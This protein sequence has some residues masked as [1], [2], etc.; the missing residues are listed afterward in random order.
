MKAI[1]EDDKTTM[2]QAFTRHVEMARSERQY[3]LDCIHKAEESIGNEYIPQ[4]GHYTFDFAQTAHLP[5][6]ARQVCLLYFK[7]P[8]K[9]QLFGICNDGPKLQTT[10]IYDESQSIG[11]NS[12]KVHGSN[13]VISMLDHFFDVHSLNEATIH[14]HADNCVG[15]NKNRFVLGY[16]AWRVIKG[17]NVDIIL[18]FVLWMELWTNQAV[19][20]QQ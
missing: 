8:L 12:T 3:Y 1:T 13:A 17:L 5:Y 18:S 14:L 9:V 4:Y 7:S 2:M 19:V 16:L 20:P 6:H 11:I 10:Y 15:Q